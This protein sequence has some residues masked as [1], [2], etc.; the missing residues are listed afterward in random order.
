MPTMSP[1]QRDLFIRTIYGEAGSQ[2][3]IGQAAVAH[4][5]NNRLN[6]GQYGNDYSKVILAPKQFSL[7]NE[8]DPAGDTARRLSP[9]SPSYQRIASIVDG[10]T[11]GQISDPTN[12]AV[13]YYNPDAANPNWGPGMLNQ[14]KIGAHLFGTAGPDAPRG[15]LNTSA[16]LQASPPSASV[17]SPGAMLGSLA[18]A[19]ASDQQAPAAPTQ[20]P[21]Q[22]MPPVQDNTDELLKQIS[23]VGSFAPQESPSRQ[24]QPLPRI[25]PRQLQFAIRAR[26]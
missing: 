9:N 14:I 4:V 25:T 11:S 6:A 20:A 16:L 18:P 7:W 2:P 8:G 1:E 21:S 5:I 10:V 15:M 26:R 13:N 19:A 22:I 3:E 17:P 12:G 24:S 23:S